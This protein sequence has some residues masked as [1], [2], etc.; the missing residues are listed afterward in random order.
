MQDNKL[1]MPELRWPQYCICCGAPNPAEQL[2][3]QHAARYSSVT[4]RNYTYTT[5]TT[6]GYYLRW[7]VPCCKACQAHH[8][9]SNNPVTW[10]A[11]IVPALAVDVA[12]AVAL[13]MMGLGENAVAIAGFVAVIGL[14]FLAAVKGAAWIG[15]KR[16]EQATR[17]MGPKCTGPGPVI[18]PSSDMEA[19]FFDIP[20]QP[21][22]ESF[23][24]MNG[25]A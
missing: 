6:S 18:D 5:T 12:L 9:K 13:F 16:L 8:R 2:N 25:V 4:D 1:S 7:E 17:M 15:K 24:S 19:V 23:A 21:Y 11:L 22:A 14:S 10:A 20:N 3:L